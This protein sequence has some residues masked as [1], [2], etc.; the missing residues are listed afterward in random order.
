MSW[1]PWAKAAESAR[2][3]ADPTVRR[4]ALDDG[5]VR[6][7]RRAA[8]PVLVRHVTVP[9]TDAR[10]QDFRAWANESAHGYFEFEDPADGRTYLARVRGGVGGIRYRQTR[11]RPGPLRWEAD[12][13]LE[14]S[15][16]PFWPTN[17]WDST[18]ELGDRTH[19]YARGSAVQRLRIETSGPGPY[20]IATWG[21]VPGLSLPTRFFE[22]GTT[23]A[24]VAFLTLRLGKPPR[25]EIWNVRL[26]LTAEADGTDG[27][28]V[29]P[30]LLAAARA[31]LRL[32]FRRRG[33]EGGDLLVVPSG[34]GGA[35][36]TEPYIW[37][38]AQTE[39]VAWMKRWAAVGTF[40]TTPDPDVSTGLTA[41]VDW[42]I[43]WGG[44]GTVIDL[45]SLHSAGGGAAPALA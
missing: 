20:Y 34:I 11:R 13:V 42:A 25:A 29:G 35:D 8:D 41:Q 5:A 16:R 22:S 44:A 27:E 38:P 24:Y 32:V 18:T 17:L 30:Q 15:S 9:L 14:G 6:Q 3:E 7:V 43:V 26:R 21:P 37:N 2:L 1:P 23:A 36:V 39:G 33:V 19:V 4:T 31:G 10:F 45:V 12:L 40:D 28:A